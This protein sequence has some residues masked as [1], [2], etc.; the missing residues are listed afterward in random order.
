MAVVLSA[1]GGGAAAA[2]P[3]L[4]KAI[5]GP[6]ERD[7]QSQF[8][9]YRDLGVGI[10][11][12]SVSWAD[13]ARARPRHATNPSDPA[14]RWPSSVDTAIAEGRRYGIRVLVQLMSTPRWANGNR[15]P[16]W[17]PHHA[18]DFA[19][20]AKA[21][22]RRYPRVH[23]WM[24]WGEPSKA[25]NFQPLRSVSSGDRIRRS[26]RRGPETYARMLD[27]SYAALKHAS[28]HN[29]V[30]GGNTFTVGDVPPL[31]YV[32]LM[33]LPN[34]K[35]P[36]MD[37]YG[38][39][40]FSARRPDLHKRPLGQGY[41]DFSDLDTLSRLVDSRLARPR[42]RRYLKLFLSEFTLP[43]D[44]AN[45]EFNFW[46][47]R[48]TQ[49]DW[50]G[51]ALRITRRWSRIYSLGYLGLYDDPPRP[52]HREVNRGLIDASGHRKPAYAT[53]RHG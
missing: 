39:N 17:A 22:S 20:F 27:A 16:R 45:Y 48:Q 30:V 18:Q 4:K 12:T 8:P 2:R 35:P 51:A 33:R 25:Q 38:H 23:L 14:Y 29:L 50:L 31:I 26:Q 6:L 40:P 11:Q 7:G 1:G 36:R 42:H 28:R 43:T 52:D 10:Y 37:L 5:W 49:A 53:Y 3:T 24:I 47:S 21:A 41:A 15:D 44:H 19:A 46:V 9:I 13:V 32:K 34:G